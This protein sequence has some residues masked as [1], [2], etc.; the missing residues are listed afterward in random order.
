MNT[1]P[2]LR[3]FL[4][5][6]LCPRSS[7][8]SFCRVHCGP[9]MASDSD[10][11]RA[12]PGISHGAGACIVGDMEYA[13]ARFPSW[14][15]SV[16]RSARSA[17]PLLLMPA[18]AVAATLPGHSRARL[19]WRH[20]VPGCLRAVCVD[21][22]VLSGCARRLLP[23]LEVHCGLFE[24]GAG[25]RLTGM[26]VARRV[27]PTPIVQGGGNEFSESGCGFFRLS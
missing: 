8:L 6:F 1:H 10:S 7:C 18:G 17:L 23:G 9:A 16:Y 15:P 4:A 27:W 25:D 24:P 26:G 20:M 13:L 3:A 11:H 21:C 2:Y 12:R 5:G 22:A 19:P 14:H